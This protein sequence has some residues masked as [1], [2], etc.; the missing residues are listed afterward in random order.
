MTYYSLRFSAY[1]FYYK[2]DK[3]TWTMS[4]LLYIAS[5]RAYVRATSFF[6]LNMVCLPL[7]FFYLVLSLISCDFMYYALAATDLLALPLTPHEFTESQF[8]QLGFRTCR[9]TCWHYLLRRMNTPSHNSDLLALPLTPHEYTVTIPTFWHYLL[10]HMNTQS[11]NSDLLALPLT[12]H[13]S[14]V[15]IPTCW[16]YLLRHMNL[17]THNSCS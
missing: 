15:T 12:P 10:R 13:E 8:L 7:C 5:K 4:V 6:Y 16:H 14:T 1:K 3:N 17:P 9:S 2:G 11:H